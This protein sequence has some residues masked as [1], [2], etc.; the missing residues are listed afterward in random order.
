LFAIS[1]EK[2]NH[3]SVDKKV[4]KQI[5]DLLVT[6]WKKAVINDSLSQPSYLIVID[7]LDEIEDKGGQEFLYE[8]LSALEKEPL[9]GLKFLVTSQPD[10]NFAALCKSFSS[11]SVCYLENISHEEV[12]ADIMTYLNSALPAFKNQSR[13]RELGNKANGLFIYASRAVKYISS[14]TPE[15]QTFRMEKLLHP[16]SNTEAFD[17]DEEVLIEIPSVTDGPLSKVNISTNTR[18]NYVAISPDGKCIASSS[19]DNSTRVWN[20]FSGA[21][22]QE[23]NGHTQFV[24]SVAFSPDSKYIASGSWDKSVRVWNAFSGAQLQEL[25]GHTQ[26]VTSVAFA[27]D[28]KCIVSG[29]HDKSVRVW[30]YFS[31][32]Q[33]QELNGHTDRVTSV[34][35]SSDGKCIVSSSHDMSVR[36]WDTFSGAKLQELN[37]H[38]QFVTS[39]AFAP[40]S[41]CIASGSW[42]KS[43]RVWDVSNGAQLQELN[44]HTQPVTS[45]AFSPDGKCIVS[46]SDDMSV[47]IWDV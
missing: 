40:D 14:G 44:D 46:G 15:E 9:H 3:D 19:D 26:F 38:T 45:V 31:G 10:S 24:T 8:L 35:F 18:V 16:T 12:D 32:I 36:L 30:D 20:A 39:V 42:D 47:R 37:G 22:L 43:V 25:N 13:L 33:L 1:L 7:A 5:Q 29:S 34:A 23:L 21:Q 11:H 27:P 6:P 41:K 4:K 17:S 28:E 2:A